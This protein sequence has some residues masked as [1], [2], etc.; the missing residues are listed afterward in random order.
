MNLFHGVLDF[1]FWRSSTYQRESWYITR[2]TTWIGIGSDDGGVQDGTI[3][4]L[5]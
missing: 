1:F 2:T 3:I 4:S 5:R